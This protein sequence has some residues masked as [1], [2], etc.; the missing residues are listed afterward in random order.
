[1]ARTP[2]KRLSSL[3]NRSSSYDAL[4]A[5]NLLASVTHIE[6]H[7]LKDYAVPLPPALVSND[8]Q[9]IR[10]HLKQSDET[11]YLFEGLSGIE[12]VANEKQDNGQ[13]VTVFQQTLR[14]IPVHNAYVT[15]VQNR[16]GT[17]SGV[18]D[19][20]YQ[21]LSAYFSDRRM[22][23]SFTAESV[24]NED[25]AK[26]SELTSESEPVFYF[27]GNRVRFGWQ[28]NTHIGANADLAVEPDF[29]SVIN[30][31]SS[32]LVSQDRPAD[33]I[34]D[35]IENPE[36]ETGV[37]PRIVIN[38]TIGAS[39]SQAY[40]VDFDAVASLDL[41]C[42]GT[43]I[44]P[45]VVISARH[46]GSDVGDTISFGDDSNAPTYTATVESVS[47][48]AGNGTLL[49]GGDV[50]ILTL[51]ADVPASIATPMRFIDAT[52]EL[53]GQ[54]AATVGYGWNGVGSVGHGGS[55]DGLRWG[56]ENIIDAY[57]SP[58]SSTGSN[59]ISTDFDDGTTDN[60]TIGSS[61]STPLQ[62]EATTAPGD[63]GGP[64]MVQVDGE[65]VI[66]GVLSGGTT[67]Q[68][69]Y[70]DISW[71][72]G[73]A[74]YRAEIEAAGGTFIGDGEGTV[75]LD[76]TDYLVGD[77]AAI[78]VVD[79]NGIEPLE[80]TLVSDSGDT[81]TITLTSGTG[82]NFDGTILISDGTV[83]SE[84]GIL[85]GSVGDEITVTYVDPDDGSG[86]SNTV[87][88]TANIVEL[89]SGSIIG[90]DFDSPTNPSPSAWLTI[91]TA[92]NATFSDLG[93]EAGGLTAVDLTINELVDGDWDDFD[94]DLNANTVPQHSN[95][96]ANLTGQI[97]TGGDSIELIYSDLIP[98]KN[99]EV[100]VMAAEGFF[101][102]IDQ[103]VTIAG[104]GS[105]VSFD[106]TF[107]IEDLFINDQVGDSTRDLSEYAQLIQADAN[108]EI[109][110]T[111]DPKTDGNDVVLAGVAI[112]D[113]NTAPT[114]ILLSNESVFEN[115]DTSSGYEIG[116]LD[117]VDVDSSIFDF[118][119]IGGAGDADN[120]SFEIVDDRLRL[121]PGVEVDFETQ[122][123]Y[124]V[125]IEVS[126]GEF[127]FEKEMLI[128]VVDGL[129]IGDLVIGDGTDQRSRLETVV[130]TFD[131]IV[132]AGSDAFE[133]TKRGPTGG[134]VGVTSD[135]NNSTGVSVVTLTF[136][137]QFVSG[138]SL[139]DGNYELTIVGT[140]I[141]STSTG[142]FLDGD[143][144][145]VAGGDFVFGSL[146]EDGFFRFFGDVDG[147]RN[148]SSLDLLR[149]RQ[150]FGSS[151]TDSNYDDR[152][153][154]D[155]DELIS[156]SDLLRF[157]QNFGGTLD[158]E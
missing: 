73:T 121:V 81:E 10:D 142:E 13:V 103:S 39:G 78:R 133:L 93:D 128:D 66:A 16:K 90:I 28:V 54:V 55:A 37:Y 22:I 71:W 2:R 34:A 35:L 1:M 87:T 131:D 109:T 32:R 59:I 77:T 146:E 113:V 118:A 49:D 46:C 45:N 139:V 76:E 52:T 17:V 43:L 12:V 80:V 98:L 36:I 31:Y 94:V 38:D 153:D 151:S 149:F 51:T 67:A 27:A 61:S 107:D 29:V 138:N 9:E 148:V 130:I 33:I 56:G 88:D 101:D 72:T 64:V 92:S 24:A 7:P 40:A 18:Y 79:D 82:A 145:G 96:L 11:S 83:S 85:Q 4:E 95:A 57:G 15:V 117:G 116:I 105:P 108:G 114:D 47:L 119:L 99:Y 60:N 158:F 19:R 5:R 143:S 100:Y 140:E 111:V 104:E 156:S 141:Q 124:A 125:R 21:S 6:V 147:D 132:T 25:Y 50:E 65:W 152:F 154:S 58:A 62:F 74:I 23:D 134:T 26:R 70:S 91:G 102:T 30:I 155:D 127:T 126:D 115:V 48:P 137:G 144:D 129:E 123:Q 84:D 53:V 97:Y 8:I 136:D 42:T 150:A 14:N 157:R 69:V 122:S 112:L 44:A 135:V 120:A 63:S 86:G 3:Q 41:G 75:S 20:A 106:Q 68:S 89:S 110:I